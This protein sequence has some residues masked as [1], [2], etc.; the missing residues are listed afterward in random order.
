[1]AT[2]LMAGQLLEIEQWK[3]IKRIIIFIILATIS[4]EFIGMLLLIPIFHAKFSLPEACFFSLFHAISSFCNAGI[5]LFNTNMQ[6]YAHNYGMLFI[7]TLLI[8]MGGLGFI[9]WE[10]IIRYGIAIKQKKRYS[11]SLH[12]KIILY[13]TTILIATVALLL[14]F[15]EYKTLFSSDNFFS[16]PLRAL[17]Y[18]VS[19]RSTGFLTINLGT[20]QVATFLLIMIVTFI[21]SSPGSTGSGIK[22]TSLVI[23]LA[24]IKAAISGQL[25]VNIKGRRIPKD[26]VLKSTTI[27]A[28]S[29]FWI[30]GTTFLLLILEKEHAFLAIIFE[31][32]SA[33]SNLGLSTGITSLLTTS[34]KVLIIASM[35]AG[36]VGSLTLLLAIR[37]IALR[38]QTGTTKFI[39]PEERVMLS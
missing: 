20:L 12:S 10:E 22:I 25:S 35:I 23:F 31:T 7:T 36:R 16:A 26:L 33:F 37:K 38:Q 15:L 30:L 28:L 21:G 27:I 3:N 18:A 8:F 34:S 17:F 2:Q 14:L 24:T 13:G 29:V 1:M 11:F 5:S 19:F 39:Y 6:Q 9:V 32:I 4:I